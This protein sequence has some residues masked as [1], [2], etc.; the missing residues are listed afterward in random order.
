MS[1]ATYEDIEHPLMNRMNALCSPTGCGRAPTSDFAIEST[2]LPVCRGD[3]GFPWP[4]P[5]D[6]THEK[7]RPYALTVPPRCLVL[8]MTTARE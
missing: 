3:A 1:L 7:S 8:V 2:A 5:A 6:G 4:Y